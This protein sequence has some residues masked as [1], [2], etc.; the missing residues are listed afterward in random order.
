[1]N[2]VDVHGYVAWAEDLDAG[3]VQFQGNN[4]CRRFCSMSAMR[5]K[6]SGSQA[7][8][9]GSALALELEDYRSRTRRVSKL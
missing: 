4:S 3:G 1:M 8:G 9:L 5:S 6:T 7:F 2:L